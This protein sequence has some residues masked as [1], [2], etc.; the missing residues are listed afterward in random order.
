MN[1]VVLK[2]LNVTICT[3]LIHRI[4]SAEFQCASL[5]HKMTVYCY[6]KDHSGW[7][8]VLY[9]VHVSFFAVTVAIGANADVVVVGNMFAVGQSGQYQAYWRCINIGNS[10]YFIFFFR[11]FFCCCC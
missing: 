4:A 8:S 2:C 5:E 11:S 7:F 1:L 9:N 3:F 6:K 10:F